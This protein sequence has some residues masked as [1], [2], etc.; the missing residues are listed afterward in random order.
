MSI[1]DI[2][3]AIILLIGFIKGI[4]DGLLIEAAS[5]IALVV[6]IYG[7]IHFSYFAGDFLKT[8]VDWEERYITLAAFTVTFVVIVIVIGA[9]GRLLTKLAKFALLE[10][11]NKIAGGLF[12]ALK[13]ALIISVVLLIFDR[14]NSKMT[15]ITP[16]TKQQSML[17]K[18]MKNLAP[19]LFPNFIKVTPEEE[20]EQ[21]DILEELNL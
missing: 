12:G 13:W 1:F 17:Y 11:V 14:F 19:M 18:P 15:F 6:G 9:A 4:K 2:I 20:K 3:I 7:A 10:W 16:E 8:K 21:Q 5:L